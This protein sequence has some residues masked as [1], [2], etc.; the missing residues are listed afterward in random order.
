MNIHNGCPIPE[1]HSLIGRLPVAQAFPRMFA[2]GAVTTE[3]D[4]MGKIRS[5]S[6]KEARALELVAAQLTTKEIAREL[7]ITPRA[8]EERLRSAR[9][10]LDAPDRR[11]AARLFLQ[12]GKSCGETTGMPATVEIG[13][14]QA[15]RSFRDL[16]D[17]SIFTLQDSVSRNFAGAEDAPT[18]LEAFDVRFGMPGRVAAI[19]L[20]AAVL[21]LLGLAAV[22]IAVT[23]ERMV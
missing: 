10:K 21:G 15:P 18:F 9:E 11:A 19:V 1:T 17:T 14:I 16:P 12:G 4:T 7:E 2:R 13:D 6:E 20:L 22:S 23:L 5:L 8:V 3:F